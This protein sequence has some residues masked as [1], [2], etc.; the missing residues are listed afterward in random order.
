MS[1][2]SLS[3]LYLSG[4]IVAAALAVSAPAALAQH[5]SSIAMVLPA[6]PLGA[7]IRELALRSGQTILVD[8][9]LVEGVNG[10]ALQGA[11]TVEAAL[12]RQLAGTGLVWTR[13]EGTIIIRKGRGSGQ[14]G[15]SGEGAS[16]LVTG[17]R[18]RGAPI[19]SPVMVLDN[20]AIRDSGLA[21]LGDVARSLPQSFG[22]GQNPG[23]GFNVPSS[24]GGNVGGGSSVNLRG[25]GS[26]ATLTVLNGRRVPYDSARQASTFPLFRLQR[27]IGL[28]WWRTAPRPFT[29]RTRSAASST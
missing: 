12:D 13:I 18:I 27:S 23:V 28:R 16:L 11:F 15:E 17:S 25:L 29:D 21:D 8:A 10:P 6:Q 24:T 2:F 14:D 1:P 5:S 9:D 3:A 26:D 7:S 22:G 19:P 20:R 4:S